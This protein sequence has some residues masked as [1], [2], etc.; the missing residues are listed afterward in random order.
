MPKSCR[1]GFG[2]KR[3]GNGKKSNGFG[4]LTPQQIAVVAGLLTN[5]LSVESILI[6]KD[7]TFEIVLTGSFRR[8]TKADRVAEQLDEVSVGELIDAFL[9]RQ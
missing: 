4:K 8:K 2:D 3:S 5:A 7:Q 9:R 1:N 6:N